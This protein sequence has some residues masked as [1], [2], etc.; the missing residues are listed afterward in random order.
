MN[1]QVFLKSILS[2]VINTLYTHKRYGA[3][4]RG[5]TDGLPPAAEPRTLHNSDLA[6]Q[7]AVAGDG[8]TIYLLFLSWRDILQCNNT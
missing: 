7:P 8:R 6:R 5:R 3:Q 1:A 2:P 4:A